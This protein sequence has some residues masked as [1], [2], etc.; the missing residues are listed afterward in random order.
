METSY[1]GWTASA[2]PADFGGLTPLVIDGRSFPPGFRAGPVSVVFTHYFRDYDDLVEDLE[3]GDPA[4]DEWS[5]AFRLNRNANNLSCHGSA[6]AGDA[7][8]TLHPNGVR[9][10]LNGPSKGVPG[11]A[12][13]EVIRTLTKGKYRGL[14]RCGEDFIGTPDGMHHEIIGTEGQVAALAAELEG[15]PVP[16]GPHLPAPAPVTP[17]PWIM[18]PAVRSRPMSFQRWY[19]AYP[20]RPALLPIIKPLANNFGPQSLDA[21]KKVQRR[22]GLVPD[23]IDGPLTKRVLWNLGWRG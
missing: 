17:Q 12:K 23:G 5:Y 13:I 3:L 9:G 8:A 15:L 22:Y 4:A 21:L 20:F 6:T 19:N 2:N 7:N 11:Q 10:T 1:N 14:I 18:L 16:P